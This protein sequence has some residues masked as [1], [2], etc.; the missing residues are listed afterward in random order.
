MRLLLLAVIFL[1]SSLEQSEGRRLEQTLKFSSG[2]CMSATLKVRDQNR[3]EID[4]QSLFPCGN[5]GK[6]PLGA[7]F[8]E[9][10]R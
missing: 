2:I 5:F 10:S 7:P 4:Q 8:I 6:I 9:N 3:I 1:V